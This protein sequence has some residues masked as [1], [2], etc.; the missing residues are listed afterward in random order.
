MPKRPVV[1]KTTHRINFSDLDPYNHLRTALYSAYYVDHRMIGLREYAGWDLR[2][3]GTLPFMTWVRRMEV[4]FLKPVVGDRAITI[5]SFVREFQG[6]D[7]HIECTMSDE[8][9]APLSR[10]LMV[11]ACV[12]KGTKRA[13]DWPPDARA[14]FFE[15]E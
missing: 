12:D 2:T 3:L 13:M 4:D 10:C 7:A 11:V 5:S 14:L 8:T 15:Q 9:G 1:Y 6:P